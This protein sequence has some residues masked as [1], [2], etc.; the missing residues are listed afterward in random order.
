M[1][2]N[3]K[4]RNSTCKEWFNTECF[5]ARKEYRKAKRLYKHYGSNVFKERLKF[6]ERFYK[7]TLDENIRKYNNDLRNKLKNMRT[8]NPKDFWKIFNKGRKRDHSDISIESL[9][10]FFKDLNTNKFGPDDTL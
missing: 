4:Y 9:F 3:V 2:T 6:S 10:T 1:N 5:K 7:K 8:K